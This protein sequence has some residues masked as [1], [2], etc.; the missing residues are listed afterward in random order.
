MEI[1]GGGP[2][3]EKRA[4]ASRFVTSAMVKAGSPR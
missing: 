4:A 2:T 3:G 1:S